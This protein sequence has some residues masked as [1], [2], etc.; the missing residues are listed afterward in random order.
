MIKF[1]VTLLLAPFMVF[2]QSTKDRIIYLD[3]LERVANE[4]N[5]QILRIMKDYYS[6]A[7]GCLVYDYYKSGKKKLIGNFKDKYNL[8]KSG[9]F[10]TYYENG[11]KASV[12]HFEDNFPTGK[13]YEWYEKGN[14]KSEGEF[15][16][17]RNER[18]PILKVHQYWSRIGIQ[19]VIDGNGRYEDE[20][21]TWYAEGDLKNGF[22][23]G[24]WTGSDLA[25]KTTFVEKY[26]AGVLISGVSTDSLK[27]TYKYRELYVDAEPTKTKDQYYRYLKQNLK[28]PA[29]IAN[30]KLTGKIELSFVVNKE[31]WVTKT[32]ILRGMGYGLDEE[33]VRAIRNWDQW[34]PARRRGVPYEMQFT[35]PIYIYN[36]KI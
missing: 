4:D 14:I 36:G 2:P 15:L 31:G 10:V 32:K 11:N 33:V 24:D 35:I 25:D 23:E 5:Y 27:N 16:K 9:E 7:P 18:K 1:F 30:N 29:Y 8:L 3:S 6:D 13:F 22:Q 12:L 26:K 19:R 20:G 17:F 21:P 28:I 34:K